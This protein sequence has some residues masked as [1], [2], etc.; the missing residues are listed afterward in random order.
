M[1]SMLTWIV[2]QVPLALFP[3]TTPPTC[4]LEVLSPT[5]LEERALQD[6]DRRVHWYVRLH[7]RLERTL[8]PEHLF[9]DLED[10]PIAVDA[11]HAALLDARPNARAGEFF[12]PGV[13]EVLSARLE[14]VADGGRPSEEAY[15]LYL[16]FT[17]RVP[18]PQV[19][20]RIPAGRYT[21]LWPGL[22]AALPALPQELEYRVVGSALVLVDVHAD[23]VLDVLKDA[24]PPAHLDL[25]MNSAAPQN[26]F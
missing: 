18:L 13:A 15:P 12:T 21:R 20:G 17:H 4:K 3:A 1:T 19:N 25:T 6:F 22:L 23:L 7:R 2:L 9:G 24:L 5:A 11:L 8:P 14:R 26:G 16:G 10:M